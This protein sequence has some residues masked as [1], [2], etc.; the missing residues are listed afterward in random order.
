MNSSRVTLHRSGQII[1][2]CLSS[3]LVLWV[4]AARVAASDNPCKWSD[5]LE[6]I[7]CTTEW[8]GCQTKHSSDTCD[9]VSYQRGSFGD[10]TERCTGHQ[11]G[12]NYQSVPDEGTCGPLQR[13]DAAC[14]WNTDTGKCECPYVNWSDPNVPD[15]WINVPG[16]T[17]AKNLCQECD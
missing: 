1:V 5:R 16:W 14:Q 10:P 15:R 8:C 12:S 6:S 13:W 7:S 2:C 11:E 17:Y 3:I 4:V 9:G